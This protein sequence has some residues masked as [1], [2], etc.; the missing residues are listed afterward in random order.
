MYDAYGYPIIESLS[1][2]SYRNE[3]RLL[4]SS[5]SNGLDPTKF[6]ELIGNIDK[7]K[8]EMPALY[9]MVKSIRTS[10]NY[11]TFNDE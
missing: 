1:E 9:S 4:M 11:N 5:I 8:T 3:A 10:N 7:L 6:S 2:D